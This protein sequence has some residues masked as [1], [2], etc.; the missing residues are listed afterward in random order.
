MRA[1]TQ[2]SINDQAPTSVRTVYNSKLRARNAPDPEDAVTKSG[3][4]ASGRR[5]ACCGVGREE[6]EEDDDGRGSLLGGGGSDGGAP[7]IRG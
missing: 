1:R 6:D 4:G 3:P 5:A 7:A 2:R